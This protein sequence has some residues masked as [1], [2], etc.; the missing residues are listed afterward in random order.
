[1]KKKYKRK[2]AEATFEPDAVI[3]ALREFPDGMSAKEL[4]EYLDL[5]RA[6]QKQ[7]TWVLNRLQGA[8]LLRRYG[9]D[10]RWADSNRALIGTI[11]QRRRKMI[12][13]I[14]DDKAEAARGRIRIAPEEAA[15]TF[16]GDR[17]V[18]SL[19]RHHRG[20][21]RE[22]KVELLLK[23]G[24]LR[25]VGRWQT[26]FRH[27]GFVESLDE[28]FPYEIDV[29][30]FSDKVDAAELS[31][32]SIVVIEVTR[33]PVAGTD[34][35]GRVVQYL[36]ASSAEQGIDIEIVIHKHDLPH[37][38][39]PE[40]LAEAE[41]ISPE[42]TAEQRAGR[43]DLRDVPIVTIDGETARDFDDAISLKKL[44]NG[45]FHLGVHIADVSYYVREGTALDTEARLR[46]TS[47][48]FPERAI[49][50]L[51]EKL[52]NG[53]CSLNPKV[54]RLAMSALM[55]VDQHGK[56]VSYEL[57]ETVIRS[58]ERM[59]YTHVNALLRHEAPALS[60]RYADLL[61]LFRTMEELARIL[62]RMRERRGAIDFNLPE[63]IFEF[64]DEGRIAGVL[65]AERNIAHRIIEEFMLLANETVAGHLE[66]LGVPAVYRIHEEPE[67]QRVIEFAELAR[68]YGY[69][70][71]VEGVSSHDYQRLSH[72]LAG[73]PEERVLAY[74]MLRSLQRARYTAFNA[75]HFGLAAPVYTHFTSPIRRYPDLLVHRILRA[76]L[77]QSPQLGESRVFA[78]L[79]DSD[80]EGK[81]KKTIKGKGRIKAPIPAAELEVMADESSQR[82]R[83]ADDA[84]REID[85]WRKAVFMAE[86]VGEEFEGMIVNVREF[87][88]FVELDEFFIEGLVAVA[89]LTDD[90]YDFNE[91]MHT[92]TGRQR[93]KTYRLGDRVRVRVERVNVDRHLV[94]FSVVSAAPP[95]R[96]RRS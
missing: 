46:G 8:G 83:A 17:V 30:E 78:S 73:R 79:A 76:L 29:E 52:S 61:E 14:P 31:E 68:A 40:V 1:M 41:N 11:R 28:K 22:G 65:K 63:S 39:P 19:F 77:Q 21:D 20:A 33:Y 32:G 82:E 94:D 86:R 71:P 2:E 53:I 25:I 59:T 93:R 34:P 44:D 81:K 38:F 54:D 89:S 55:E 84:E 35:A 67:P 90:Y 64:D 92:L 87:G 85:E 58:N 95:G 72:Q 80:E 36:G 69:R 48:Y 70:F 57:R 42:V 37:I 15:G 47:V 4:A 13:F 43:L 12:S 16:D 18:I 74:A 5:N 62:I 96:S 56:V 75:G 6:Q 45:N 49:P 50:M 10:F 7:L 27:H 60:M 9:N 3:A 51:P 91:R 26:T 24:T 23:R 66:R 88:F